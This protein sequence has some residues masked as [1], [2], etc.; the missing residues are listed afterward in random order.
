M[1]ATGRFLRL[2]DR[3]GWE[4]VER[5]QSTGVVVIVAVTDAEGL[6]LVEQFRRALDAR[7]IELPAGL[8]GDHPGQE[9]EAFERAA[10]RELLEETGYEAE[11]MK[12]LAEGPSS[13]GMS[14][15]MYSFFEAQ[16][17]TRRHAGGGDE[18]E[19]ILVH[20]VPLAGLRAWLERENQRGA[21]IDPRIYAGLALVGRLLL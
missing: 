3:R 5:S 13:S 21:L 1:L 4:Y 16:G 11:A 15:E 20:E 9:D 8:V 17:L 7:V 14:S 19:D 2:V 10:Q 12:F 6:L 18:S